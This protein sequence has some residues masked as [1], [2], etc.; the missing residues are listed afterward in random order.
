MAKRLREIVAEASK[1]FSQA[2]NEKE[3]GFIAKHM[4]GTFK[5]PVMDDSVFTASNIKKDDSEE[6]IPGTAHYQN[7]EDEQVYERALSDAEKKRKEE[8]VKGLKKAAAD[9][10]DRYGKDAQSVMH[11]LATNVAKGEQIAAGSIPEERIKA[12]RESLNKQNK[13]LF[14]HMMEYQ[15]EEAE[16][17]VKIVEKDLEES[18]SV[19]LKPHGSNAFKVHSVGSKMK[20]HGG[21]KPGET[22]QD[23]H[24][25]DLKD[26]GIKVTIHGK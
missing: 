16:E 4:L 5:H 13:E 25:D 24:V 6:K 15:P 9:F 18:M 22:I 12:V 17:F 8:V 26:S 1:D 14:D 3:A 10:E 23:R 11:G 19:T 20:A 7:G 21:M 2:S